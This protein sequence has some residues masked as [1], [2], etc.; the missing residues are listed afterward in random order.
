MS[1][2]KRFEV[3]TLSVEKQT[4]FQKEKTFPFYTAEERCYSTNRI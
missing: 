3:V 1:N 4:N 2:A